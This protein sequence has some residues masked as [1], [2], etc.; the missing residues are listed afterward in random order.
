MSSKNKNISKEISYEERIELMKKNLGLK[1]VETAKQTLKDGKVIKGENALKNF[2]TEVN[3]LTFEIEELYP[4]TYEEFKKEFPKT[5]EL[6]EIVSGGT[7]VSAVKK[8]IVTS[9]FSLKTNVDEIIENIKNNVEDEEKRKESIQL[10]LDVLAETKRMK[11]EF[12]IE[13]CQDLFWKCWKIKEGEAR[14]N[15]LVKT[16]GEELA[17]KRIKSIKDVGGVEFLKVL[18]REVYG[19]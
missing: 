14:W 12:N 2:N 15:Y 1:F 4:L 11:D 13:W 6:V 3:E 19:E 17:K 9:G 16:K 7:V 8:G 18:Q 5:I 10:R